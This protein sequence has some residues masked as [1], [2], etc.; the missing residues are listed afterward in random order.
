MGDFNGHV[1]CSSNV[2]SGVHG[3]FGYGKKNCEGERL[4][5]LT[6]SVD[7]I[8]GNTF[9]K[10][11]PEKLILY[12]SGRHAT[13]VDY[14]L[15]EKG[16]LKMIKAVKV[17]PEEC[18]A[19]HRLLVMDMKW[20]KVVKEKASMLK[21]QVKLWKLKDEKMQDGWVKNW[22]ERDRVQ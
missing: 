18:F 4:L 1:G 9:F 6:D 8:V 21:R 22:K 7:M 5:E 17:I 16:D 15:M 19:Q 13:V 14:I 3:G 20:N 11:D 2:Y 12:K 10:E